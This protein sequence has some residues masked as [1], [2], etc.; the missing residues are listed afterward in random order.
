[1]TEPLANLPE[2]VEAFLAEYETLCRK[3]GLMVLSE[4]EAVE[5]CPVDDELWGIR[6]STIRRL[7]RDN[8][9]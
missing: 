3:H 7:E 8:S 5:V 2:N 9:R 6:E 1:M 4:G